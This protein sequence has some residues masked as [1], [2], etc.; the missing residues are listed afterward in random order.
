MPARLRVVFMGTPAFAVPSLE[1]LIASDAYSIVGVVTQPDAPAGRGRD[2]AMSPVKRVAIE[3]GLTVL[4]PERVRRPDAVAALHALQPD[5]Q[6]VAAF[7]QI[8]PRSVLDIPR[9]ATL[10]VHASL[11]PRWRGAA[12]ISAAILAGD[13]ETG[14]TIMRLDEGMDTGD[15]LARS[16][17]PI[18]ADDTTGS[19][20][21]RLAVLGA[22]LLADTLP[23]WVRGEITPQAQDNTLATLCKPIR[24]ESGRMDWT[25]PAA[26][27]ERAVR[28]YAPWPGTFTYWNGK[29][30]KIISA[31]ALSRQAGAP[32][33]TVVSTPDGP[34]VA[35]AAGLLL[36]LV[37]QLEGKRAL[38]TAE[39]VRGQRDFVGARLT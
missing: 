1:R 2:L 39:F 21:T 16:A 19:L 27:L 25:Q 31:R 8:L 12:P 37:T 5:V 11:L 29:L 30:V 14:I 18:R 22:D 36:L 4:Q 33:G 34:A 9:F 24:K 23:R 28:A 15:M 20:T 17:T 35:T 13:N 6:I 3:H 7:G 10:N 32:P 38:P 26:V